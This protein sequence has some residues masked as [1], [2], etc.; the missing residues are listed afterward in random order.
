MNEQA[1]VP[2]LGPSEARRLT[3]E[4]KRDAETLW[5]RLIELHQA[6]AH[7]AL[8]YPAWADYCSTEFGFGRRHAYRLLEAGRV[9]ERVSHGSLNERQARELAPLLRDEDEDAVVEVWRELQAEHGDGLTAE[10]IRT[11][12]EKKLAPKSKPPANRT[13][14]P[15]ADVRRRL[16]DLRPADELLSE[17]EFQRAVTD[18]LTAFGWKW[19]HFRPGQTGRGWR[20]PLSGSPG[21][22]DVTAV[23]G[24]RVIWLELKAEKGRATDEQEAWIAALSAAGQ[25]ARVF[26]PSDWPTLEEILR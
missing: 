3:N 20:T 13:T 15:V 24:D 14:D 9:A 16:S 17:R 21:Y 25:E 8:G 26:R 12:V 5:R 10:K 4:V 23:R 18:A 22:P 6:G 1:L 2:I 7:T 19:T 11:A